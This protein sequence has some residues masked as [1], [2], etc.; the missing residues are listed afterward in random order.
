MIVPPPAAPCDLR[1]VAVVVAARE[2]H[3]QALVEPARRVLV[4]VVDGLVEDEVGQL[5]GDQLVDPVGV[6]LAWLDEPEERA[7]AGMRLAADVLARGRAHGLR[8]SPRVS[9]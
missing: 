2:V 9:E 3:R 6:D 8:G 1:A 7:D 5:V 4:G